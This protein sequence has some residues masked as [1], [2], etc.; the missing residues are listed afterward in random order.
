MA[1]SQDVTDINLQSYDITWDSLDL[2]LTFV[3]S[4]V[5]NQ[6]EQLIPVAN[7]DQIEGTVKSFSK[8]F[9]V[10]VTATF[11]NTSI[12]RIYGKL[13]QN[14]AVLQSDGTNRYYSLRNIKVDN[15]ADAKAL[16]LHPSDLP[17]TDK[18]KDYY[19]PLAFPELPDFVINGSRDT[20][21]QMQV[22]F[23]VFPDLNNNNEVLRA[24][25]WTVTPT[26]PDYAFIA[27]GSPFQV[28][29]KSLLALDVEAGEKQQ[30]SAGIVYSANST[31]TAALNDAGG[32]TAT[33]TSLP[34]DTLSSDNA[35]QEGSYLE[36]DNGGS[37]EVVYVSSITY[38]TSTTGTATIA[39][40]IWGT[41]G[42]VLVDNDTITI[43]NTP[44]IT[45]ATDIVTWASSS[46][47]NVTVGN[48]RG[49]SDA[50]KKGVIAH[51][52][53]GSA[54]ITATSGATVSPN[55]VVTAN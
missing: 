40:G 15:T 42:I 24:G 46:A 4:V 39:R 1:T 27:T 44:A 9:V 55:L 13:M 12:E 48:V 22:T 45:N 30:I 38:A 8:G 7:V 35:I 41:S 31:V 26:D 37:Q 32:L 52:A 34:F 54:N 5:I 6:N 51:V 14:K 28:P 3:D 50:T 23:V 21:Q 18:S 53:A 20:V 33:A 25:D 47:S 36:L 43:K 11:A 19:L 17:S 2:G 16:I 29:A 49:A 10:N